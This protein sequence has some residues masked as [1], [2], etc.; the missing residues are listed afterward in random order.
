M[1]KIFQALLGLLLTLGLAPPGDAQKPTLVVQV[2]HTSSV[3]SVVFSPDD[4]LIASGSE[5]QTIKLWDTKTGTELL[6]LRGHI[7]NVNS[8]AFSPDGK[9]LA[10]GSGILKG[11][12]KLWSTETG[13]ELQFLQGHDGTVESLA[14]RPDGRVLA[15]C[16]RDHTIIFWDVQSGQMLNTLRGHE[17]SVMSL[18]FSPDGRVLVSGSW[19]KTVRMWDGESG[20]E[21][22]TLAK[23]SGEVWAVAFNPNGQTFASA[24]AGIQF[25]ETATGKPLNSL[26]SH[27]LA[28][29]AIA[30]APNGKLL[31]SGAWDNKIRLWDLDTGK[32]LDPIHDEAGINSLAFSHD[33]KMLVSGTVGNAVKI[34]DPVTRQSLK[35]LNGHSS[36]V[37]AVTFTSDN[38]SLATGNWDK[39]I[40]VW[41]LSSDKELHTLTAQEAVQSVVF[42]PKSRTL[43]SGGWEKSINIWDLNSWKEL[44][45]HS[46]ASNRINSLAFHPNGKVFASGGWDYSLKLWSDD[47]REL[48]TLT[49]RPGLTLVD[50][51]LSVAFSPQGDILASGSDD[52]T[53][54]LWNVRQA[55][56]GNTVTP[57]TLTPHGAE[58]NSV[59]F[60]PSGRILASGS[61]DQT[62]RL[63]NVRTG[64]ILRVLTGHSRPVMS[65]AFNRNGTVLASAG[66]DDTVRLW[67]VDKGREILTLKGH[68][69]PVQT[70]S[71]SRDGKVLASGSMDATVKLWEMPSGKE[72]A[73][74]IALDQNDWLVV[75]PDGLF[76]GTPAAW[77][78]I[79]WRFSPS[80][81]EVNPV[82]SFYSDFYYPGLLTE[83]FNGQRPRAKQS[84]AQKDRRN[85]LV[86]LAIGGE[87]ISADEKIA[88][89]TV[90]VK[91]KIEEA[92]GGGREQGSGVRDVRL[93]RNGLLVRRWNGDIELSNEGRA[94]L[95]VNVPIIAGDNNFVAYAFNRDDVKSLD[96]TRTVRGGE[97]LARKGTAYILAIG[98]NKYSNRNFN[99]K[100][101]EA[102]A[103]DVTRELIEQQ[104]DL[105]YFA[106]I[107]PLPLL[108][109]EATK[110]NILLALKRF[111]GTAPTLPAG[112]PQVLQKIRPTEPEDLLV[113]YFAGHGFARQQQFYFMSHNV[114]YNGPRAKAQ[115]LANLPTIIRHSISDQDLEQA[116]RDVDAANILLVLDTCDSGQ[117]LESQEQR[118]GPM[119]SKGLA[120]LAYEKGMYILTASQSYQA[121]LGA[122][123]L[124]HGYLTYALIVEG[125]NEGKADTLPQDGQIML[126]EWF[127]Y[128]AERVPQLLPA[129]PRD[130]KRLYK[131]RSERR[132]L[133]HDRA[134]TGS[135]QEVQQ[136]RVFYRRETEP[137]PLLIAR[138]DKN[139]QK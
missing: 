106:R 22:R 72:L 19:D 69:G 48:R 125:L 2:G 112:A 50:A 126:R 27:A 37:D 138:P 42:N 107:E 131:K 81:R 127:V 113:I 46:G 132:E 13:R 63:W 133:V 139:G 17:D 108:N 28:V 123:R 85:P 88:N 79:L 31:A 95:E 52:K 14:F 38:K 128:A 15:S 83:L 58:V 136:P 49:S 18:A 111:A 121:A 122:G 35:V 1:K 78:K 77:N 24:G 54:R 134:S 41:D 110:D 9:I 33:G 87:N 91:I 105:P 47:G 116:L 80:L 11:E 62:I 71:F 103:L 67:N 64:K 99:L 101:A 44:R 92:R 89:R 30:Y 55:L 45:L 86:E 76:D 124:G 34:W 7:F 129:Q 6:S 3:T 60:S 109:E 29:G 73:T 118:R 82:E 43:V 10:S 119:N 75:T 84:I 26:P 98:I 12:I 61:G 93:F 117:V 130:S 74:L 4:S 36:Y 115:V 137:N 5:D 23:Q 104:S 100:Y 90:S 114:G 56:A 32:E 20:K 39:T 97:N 68:Q 96:A 21:I 66:A 135:R 16:S 8:V 53:I 57:R 102:D 59:A 94:T 65:V 40:R 120:Q 70:V 51:I 25:W